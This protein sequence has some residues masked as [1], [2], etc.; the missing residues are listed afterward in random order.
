MGRTQH[1]DSSEKI[2]FEWNHYGSLWEFLEFWSSDLYYIS[3][4]R[5]DGPINESSLKNGPTIATVR[6]L[7]NIWFFNVLLLNRAI[8]G[9]FEGVQEGISALIR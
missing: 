6:G 9:M 5:N 3:K 1:A 4:C 2:V 8:F 7:A